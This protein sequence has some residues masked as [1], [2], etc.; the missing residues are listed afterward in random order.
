MPCIILDRA[1]RCS[2]PDAYP[3][4]SRSRAPRISTVLTEPRRIACSPVASVGF[5]VVDPELV[6]EAGQMLLHGGLGHEQLRRDLA[7]RRRFA[8]HLAREHRAAQGD[9]HLALPA[10]EIARS[11]RPPSLSSRG[12]PDP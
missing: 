9:E 5:A 2:E 7:D 12:P 4:A 1:G 10:G 6:V 11:R 3:S 8:E